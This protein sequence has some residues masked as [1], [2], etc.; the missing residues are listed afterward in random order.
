MAQQYQLTVQVAQPD[1]KVLN[2][3]QLPRTYADSTQVYNTLS[4]LQ[5]SLQED[6]YWEAKITQIIDTNSIVKAN[7]VVGQPFYWKTLRTASLPPAITKAVHY[8]PQT[9][10]EKQFDY[11][12]ISQLQEDI[13]SYAEDNG[14]PFATIQL[15][16]LVV[17]DHS[18]E[19]ALTYQPGLAFSFDSLQIEGSMKLKKKFLYKYLGVKKGDLYSQKKVEEVDAL[20]KRF[21]FVNLKKPSTTSFKSPRAYVSVFADQRRANQIDGIIGL[22]PNE[23][24]PG[25]VLLTGQFDLKL[26]NLF[27]R[28]ISFEGAYQRLT[29]TSELLDIRYYHP[30]L[31][32]ANIDVQGD[33]NLLREDTTF[34]N[35]ERK[36]TFLYNL[37]A[38]KKISVFVS[39]KT[40][41]LGFSPPADVNT[42]P[43]AAEIN[44][45]GYGLGYEWQTLDNYYY[46][47]NGWHWI[48]Q[49]LF[50]NKEIIRNPAL[51]S[52]LYEGI[53]EVSLQIELSA[54]LA[55][56]RQ[57]SKRQ[58]LVG[59]IRGS[60]LNNANL[61]TNDLFRLG[62]LQSLRGF[63]QNFF[64]A[65]A[66]GVGTLEYRF[67]LDDTSYL[68]LFYDQAYLERNTLQE[69]FS[70]TPLGIG[71]GISFTTSAG[72]FNLIYA[73]GR[74]RTQ[75]L[76]F[77][78]SKVHFGFISRF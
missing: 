33:F 76:D 13:L 75:P 59:R 36:L 73:V 29:P 78:R 74:D 6:G 65:S 55:Y 23:L 47:R 16:S 37:G 30:A 40:S 24:S 48:S 42:L 12:V 4:Q 15:D 63:N 46:P 51:Q 2:R 64:F 54:V 28:A 44:F 61:F 27:Q 72:I 8:K 21:P 7:L 5:Q 35:I 62:G 52:E 31:L 17:E 77:N 39:R 18:I 58:I 14:Y 10:K 60:Y 43:D 1:K 50:G 68:L 19:A 25:S 20:L 49:G 3:Y 67:L 26:R 45:T 34:L 71:A 57:I 32:G 53:E 38:N 9:F 41:Q 66:Y 70:D 22:L 56:Y 11:A 69:R